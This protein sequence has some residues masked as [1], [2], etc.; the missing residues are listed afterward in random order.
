M[1]GAGNPRASLCIRRRV[2]PAVRGQVRGWR[3][4]LVQLQLD[5]DLSPFCHERPR[6]VLPDTLDR[7][8]RR[9]PAPRLDCPPELRRREVERREVP[10][11]LSRDGFEELR[12]EL[13]PAG[14]GLLSS[15]DRLE[16]MT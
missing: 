7:D 15:K 13:V 11:V 3:E 2:L 14:G 16:M 12:R 5:H 1:S 8:L 9:D 6:Q 4:G 10:L